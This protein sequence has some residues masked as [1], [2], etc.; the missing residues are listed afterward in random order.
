VARLNALPYS[1]TCIKCQRE[2]ESNPG[3]TSRGGGGD[4]ANPYDAESALEER[5]DIDPADIEMHQTRDR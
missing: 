3:C 2:M 1:T 4:W 5:C